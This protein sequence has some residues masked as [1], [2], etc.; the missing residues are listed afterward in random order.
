MVDM[1]CRRLLL[2]SGGYELLPSLERLAGAGLLTANT[3]ASFPPRCEEVPDC[4]S[5]EVNS[6]CRCSGMWGP[7]D[8]LIVDI[9]QVSIIS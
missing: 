4:G 5:T 7:Y 1:I 8:L 2:E 6:K 3:G 9:L